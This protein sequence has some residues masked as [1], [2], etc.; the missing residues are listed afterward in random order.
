[1]VW[2]IVDILIDCF[3]RMILRLLNLLIKLLLHIY[4]H[5]LS[6]PL[7]VFRHLLVHNFLL[8]F[9][10][11]QFHLVLFGLCLHSDHI[12][13]LILR[14]L[15]I[16]ILCFGPILFLVVTCILL[17]LFYF[18]M[19]Y[20]HCI[21]HLVLWPFLHHHHMVYHQHVCVYLLNNL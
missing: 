15:L 5:Y 13:L 17:L 20:M 14:F 16:L 11:Q 21:L 10:H 19:N 3:L 6:I 1:M 12:K 8:K 9:L 7:L 4:L 2:C 18:L